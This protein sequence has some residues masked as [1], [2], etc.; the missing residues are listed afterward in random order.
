MNHTKNRTVVPVF[1]VLLLF[2]ACKQSGQ[3]PDPIDLS[4]RD[5][6]IRP[7]DDF[8][9]YA[10]G[11]WIK[12]TV[13][14]PS[15][16]AW[17]AIFSLSDHSLDNI[18]H[19]LD[20]LAGQSGLAKGSV[21]QKVADLYAG[22]MDSTGIE[23]KGIAPLTGDLDRIAAIKDV[24]GVLHEVAVEYEEG[25]SP[26][27]SFQVSADDKNSSMEA[28]H[29]SQGGLG[30]PNK[31][32]YFKQDSSV[33]QIR[34][35]YVA[36]MAKTFRLLGDDSVKAAREARDVMAAETD[37]AKVSKSEVDLRDPNANYHKMTVAE[38][39]KE[40]P[41]LDWP[42]LLSDMQIHLDTLLVGQPEFYHGLDE[43]LHRIP[44]DTWKAYLRFHL[45]DG[46]TRAL[47]HEF[48]DAGFAYGR[49]FS[50]QTEIQPRWKR[51]AQMV[52][53]NLGD[54]L[55]QIYVKLY[56]PPESKARMVQLVD[57]LQAAYAR[58][59]QDASW[60]SDSTKPK[61]L[62]KLHAIVKKIGYPDHWKDY[63]GVAIDRSD[64]IADL[65]ACG[66]YEYLRDI[67]KLGKPV[68]RSEWYMTPPT[69]DAYYN[70][71][72]NDINFP[73]GILQPPFFFPDGDDAVNY[74]A[75]G[76][77]I[78]HEMSHGF[79]DQGRLYDAEGNLS[80]WWT[81][82][83]SA[84]FVNRANLIVKQYDH[85]LAVD[86]FHINGKLTEGENLADV[87]GLAIAYAAFKRTPEGQD[88]TIRIDGLTPDQRFFLAFA[89]VWRVKERDA[90]LRSQVL[91]NP[92]STPQFRVN[93]PV[94][95]LNAFYT[96]FDVKPSDKM[97]VPDSLRV[98]IW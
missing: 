75:I 86:T 22:F 3:G 92:H 19:I 5:T 13:I 95:D 32:Y 48:V 94:A 51:G 58:K 54:A 83:D 65:K 45:V 9:S 50:G 18:R 71:T 88:T 46:F 87:N 70:P 64:V 15:Q 76:L 66:K 7:Q 33:R 57:N 43:T 1:A 10:N 90:S 4:A 69:V 20:S 97:Y 14:P 67:R 26:L 30:L 73:A 21:E 55:G 39:G 62:A 98:H 49:M 91:T 72:S 47:P 35:A 25:N 11:G 52:D 23:H 80:N 36:Y 61:A 28:A 53:E 74:G 89:Q 93:G 31:D 2:C 27:F 29:F 12:K 96:T 42:D 17:G 8:W 16:R 40:A 34:D 79:D 44:V 84:G 6:S 60:L 68:D 63:S 56:F 82:G 78:G 77:V 24:P 38:I 81:P 85:Y 41:G 37:L 59:I